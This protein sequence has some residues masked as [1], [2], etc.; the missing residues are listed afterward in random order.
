MYVG[1]Y[2]ELGVYQREGCYNDHQDKKILEEN[3]IA[4]NSGGAP[5]PPTPVYCIV[6]YD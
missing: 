6:H 3:H 2:S 1:S 4:V 5:A